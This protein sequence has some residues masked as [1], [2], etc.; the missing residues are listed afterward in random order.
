M[1]LL[2]D[3]GSGF[4][5]AG[6]DEAGRGCLAGPVFS[7]AVILPKN[8]KHPMLNDS[9]QVNEKNRKLLRKII[10]NEAL[11]WS[12]ALVQPQLI[13]EINILNATYEAMNSAIF[14]LKIIPGL[15]VIDGNRFKNKTKIPFRT[16]IKGDGRFLHIAAA[17]I[18]AKTH[19]DEYMMKLSEQF[20]DY[21]WHQNKGYGTVKHRTAIEAFGACEHHR[22]SF[23]LLS[24]QIKIDWKS[25]ENL[26]NV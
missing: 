8:F 21:G 7:A 2:F 24:K 9:K 22:K 18:L 19:R 3:T 25:D 1:N 14:D 5:E 26:S 16:E 12:V 23:T 6:V 11:S 4:L 20:P 10:E 17:S 15:L 13:D